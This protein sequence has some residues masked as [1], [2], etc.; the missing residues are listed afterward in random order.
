M[1][2][3]GPESRI[4]LVD[5]EPHIL[6]SLEDLLE[7]DFEV[8]TSTSAE[9]ALGLLES[10]EVAVI[11][12]DQR[13]PGLTGWE[14]LHRARELSQ[15]SRMLIT[16]YTDMQALV[17][18][19][20]E[21]QI[22]GYI[23]KPWDPEELLGQVHKA[24]GYFSLVRQL[25]HERR[26]LHTLMD[27]IPDAIFFK[28]GDSRFTR[29]NRALARDLGLD[30]PDEAVGRA[31]DEFFPGE[32]TAESAADDR[33]VISAAQPL[34]DRVERLPSSQGAARHYSTT[35]API[36]D[37]E[38]RIAG[39]VGISRDITERRFEENLRLVCQRIQGHVW[40][41]QS[42]GDVKMVLGALAEALNALGI[43]Y[44][45]CG[46]NLLQDRPDAGP[47]RSH[48]LSASGR[49][50]TSEKEA[51]GRII[52]QIMRCGDP[53]YR[54]DL[55]SED[56]HSELEAFRADGA[57]VRSVVDVPFS[58]GTLA[59][60][61]PQPHA[62]TEHDIAALTAVAEVLSE[63]FRR[64]DDLGALEEKDA[65]LRQSQK[66]EAIGQ[67][68]GGVA[69]DFNNLI[70]VITGYCQ[71]LLRSLEPD[72][73]RRASV[74]QIKSA[75]DQA[76]T[77]VRQL[78][79]FSRRQVLA[80]ERL[81]VGR[82]ITDTEKMLRR[83]IGE[84]IKLEV[85]VDPDLWSVEADPGQLEQVLM[86]L[87]V[88]GRDAMPR[89]GQLVISV[90]NAARS[91]GV[92]GIEA[93]PPPGDYV[94]LA[95]SDN[96]TGMEDDTRQRIFEP[97]FTT[98][99]A[100]KGTGLGLATVYGIVKQ[101]G[102]HITVDS[103]VG[104]GTTFG[105]YL[106]RADDRPASEEMAP[107]AVPRDSLRGSETVLLVEDDDAVRRVLQRAIVDRGYTVLEAPCGEEAVA[108]A[109]QG[110]QAIDLL[111]TD[112]VLPGLNG[113]D[114]ARR[115]AEADPHLSVICMSGYTDP[116]LTEYGVLESG[117][118]FVQ[119]PVDIDSLIGKAR[120]LLDAS[121]RTPTDP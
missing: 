42:T 43:P 118:A 78:L 114:L 62:F 7:D 51:T 65:Q 45:A 74:D 10:E 32:D 101:S 111:L 108:L 84:N 90:A 64:L 54:P 35:K 95:V 20:N 29:I 4:L 66:M 117:F 86:N 37:R 25:D 53:D 81:D 96:G 8:L 56:P 23:A 38:G 21:G 89:G 79:A 94:L 16:G 80:P 52:P 99:E 92:P 72:D 28:D 12:S 34:I 68:A 57:S 48:T 41:M 100:G 11:L 46:I 67:L 26:L 55:V 91:A 9:E 97:F 60:S 71:F 50:T 77:L 31:L 113:V 98:K 75:G 107:D 110:D 39:L 49:W 59:I 112:V 44:Y 3:P 116:V 58:H 18:A 47:V 27:S 17:H 85:R 119:K 104:S 121:T 70:T 22:Y 106:P 24:V 102:G 36:V 5:D 115:L 40:K 76:G 87:V 103:E 63:G 69:H 120:E 82:V 30:H 13:M 33:Q 83:L 19:V 93:E 14:F 61:S 109:T 73:S 1:T 105:V 15:A 88:N 6:H 2:D